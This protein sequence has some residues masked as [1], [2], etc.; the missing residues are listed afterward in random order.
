MVLNVNSV[1][2]MAEEI[3]W[4]KCGPQLQIGSMIKVDNHLVDIKDIIDI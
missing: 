2:N 1:E 3:K 4:G